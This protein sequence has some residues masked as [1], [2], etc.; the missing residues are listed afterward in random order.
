[1]VSTDVKFFDNVPFSSLPTHTS[2]GEADDLLVYTIASPVAPPLPAPVKPPITQVYTRRQNPL[3]SGPP[4]VASKSYPFPDD[5]PIALR[6]GRHQCVHPISS[7]CTYNQLSSQ[8]CSFIA[9]LDSISLPNTFQEALSHPG[10]RSAMIEEM[11]AL[12]GND[13]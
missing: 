12:D 9:S 6:K 13:T 5:L 7:F 2:Q 3:V 10:W 11:D 4:P 8:S 1:M